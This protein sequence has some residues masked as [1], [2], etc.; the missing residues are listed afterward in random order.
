MKQQTETI[1]LGI[2][3]DNEKRINSLIDQYQ[4]QIRTYQAANVNNPYATA[5]PLV[6]MVFSINV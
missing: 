1:P 5:A 4:N 6:G 3:Q 2:D